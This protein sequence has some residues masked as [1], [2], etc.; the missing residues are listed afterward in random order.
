MGSIKGVHRG[1]YK[2]L[3]SDQNGFHCSRCNKK[4]KR[5]YS[6]LQHIRSKHLEI[7]T[8]CPI[9]LKKFISKSVQTRHLKNVHGIKNKSHNSSHFETQLAAPLIELSHEA[10][11]A[12]PYMSKVLVL[13]ES[14]KF[15]THIVTIQDLVVGDVVMVAP[16]FAVVEYLE[17]T[18][19]GCFQCGKVTTTKIE[20]SSCINV[21]FCSQL[22]QA[23][24]E[25]RTKCDSIFGRQDCRIVRLAKQ[26]ISVAI[27]AI[28]NIETLFEY[29]RA[30]LLLNKTTQKCRP[31]YS[32]YGKWMSIILLN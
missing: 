9:C 2:T 12:F 16:P 10:D 26:I 17:C 4:Y 28:S 24:R 7:K 11:E 6:L 13:K 25:H 3:N 8:K 21:W 5:R 1:K 31:P 29:C 18:S 14:K 30:I 23:S 27:N 32:H 20:C 15:G 22:C 19:E